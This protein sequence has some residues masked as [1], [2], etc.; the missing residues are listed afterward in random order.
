MVLDLL[1]QVDILPCWFV[2]SVMVVCTLMS[3]FV[4]SVSRSVGW[5]SPVVDNIGIVTNK[6][7]SVVD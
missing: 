2:R 6:D 1:L 5:V 4:C 7:K 3:V